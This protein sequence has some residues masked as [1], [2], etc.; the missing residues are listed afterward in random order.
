MAIVS[1][2]TGRDVLR[3][4]PLLDRAGGPSQIGF[5]FRWMPA[6]TGAIILNPMVR[7]QR[8]PSRADRIPRD[9]A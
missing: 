8:A 1:G 4:A 2:K 7:D 9:V 6:W 3:N 5:R